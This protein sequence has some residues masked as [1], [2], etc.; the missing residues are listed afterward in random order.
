MP[1]AQKEYIS[2][3]LH[4]CKIFPARSF[5][6][7]TFAFKSESLRPDTVATT[8]QKRPNNLQQIIPAYT[9]KQNVIFEVPILIHFLYYQQ[10]GT[11]H[12]QKTKFVKT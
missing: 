7:R 5:N 6:Q 2:I 1:E 4:L 9:L 10:A 12:V 3:L 11:F 8:C